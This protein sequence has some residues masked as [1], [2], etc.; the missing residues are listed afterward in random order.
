MNKGE[1]ANDLF[2]KFIKTLKKEVP[3]GIIVQDKMNDEESKSSV[4]D[5]Y[6]D[7]E[8][9]KEEEKSEE[10]NNNNNNKNSSDSNYGILNKSDSYSKKGDKEN[11]Q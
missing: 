1:K 4:S 6:F 5:S 9:S 3:I 7:S 10:S 11:N 2:D 8:K